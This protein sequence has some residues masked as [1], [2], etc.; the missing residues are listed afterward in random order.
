MTRYL[1]PG[2]KSLMIAKQLVKSQIA[3]DFSNHIKIQLQYLKIFRKWM[4]ASF[5]RNNLN[6]HMC[7][8]HKVAA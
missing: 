2:F 1:N 3:G 5:K 6:H 8:P 7:G 4:N